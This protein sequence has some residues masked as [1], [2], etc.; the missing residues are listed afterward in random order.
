MSFAQRTLRPP[1]PWIALWVVSLLALAVGTSWALPPAPSR[2]PAAGPRLDRVRTD[3]DGALREFAE[4]DVAGD[5]FVPGRDAFEV[6]AWSR[7]GE[8]RVG[9]I[10][11]R[12][13]GHPVLGAQLRVVL[14]GEDRVRFVN[15]R[16]LWDL[17][18]PAQPSRTREQ[19]FAATR[20]TVRPR[21]ED[22]R[23][24]GSLAVSRLATGDHLVWVVDVLDGRG[25]ST[26]RVLVDAIDGRV[27]EVAEVACHA[28][29][30]VYPT[31][32]RAPL[33]ERAL[34]GW[35]G[36]S[37]TLVHS[38]YSVEARQW[39][40]LVVPDHDFRFPDG[41]PLAE[42]RREVNTYWHAQ[43]YLDDFLAPL[44]YAGPPEPFVLRV[45]E[46]LDPYIALTSGRFVFL[47]EAIAGLSRD[48]ALA[49]DIVAHELQH[50]V[51]YGFGV[52]ASGPR[53]EALALHEGVS[54]FMAACVTADPSIGEWAYVSF[55]G[56]VTRVDRPAST[57]KYS[58]YDRV[59]FGGVPTGSG[60]AN[61]M[62]LSG[63]LWDLRS[64][65]GP[66]TERL[67]LRA[68]A[69]LPDT[70]EWSHFVNAMAE[71]DLELTGGAHAA[72]L[73]QAFTA[74]E[75]RGSLSVSIGGPFAAK[76]GEA[77]TYQALVEG[78]TTQ[79][80]V[81]S[82]RRY[83]GNAP[84]GDWEVVGSGPSLM[85]SEVTDYELRASIVGLLG[86][87]EQVRFID[88]LSPGLALAGAPAVV[89]GE[90]QPYRADVTGVG[91]LGY[92]WWR[93]F[94]RPGAT[95]ERI[96]S[97]PT[98]N[99][100]ADAPYTLECRVTDALG[101]RVTRSVFVPFL[102]LSIEAPSRW[103]PGQA[104]RLLAVGNS[105]LDSLDLRW[106]VRPYCGSVPCEG[107]SESLGVGRQLDVAFNTDVLVELT[108][109]APWGSRLSAGTFL[110]V[111]WPRVGLLGPGVI[112]AR[113]AGLFV[114]D[115]NGLGPFAVQWWRRDPRSGVRTELGTGPS[116]ELRA[117]EPVD[118]VV[119][120]RDPLGREEETSR[121][122]DV[123]DV[124]G[125]GG[126][127]T[128][129]RF[130]LEVPGLANGR[131]PVRFQLAH[132]ARARV[133]VLDVTGRQV[134]RLWD[135]F[136]AAGAEELEWEPGGAGEGVYFVRLESGGRQLTRRIVL[137]P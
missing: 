119:Q 93:T 8:L 44:G 108:A 4:R 72:E 102:A 36:D 124:V 19:A 136:H 98:V 6:G 40:P 121:R 112:S 12:F 120:V 113:E 127:G 9:R 89:E 125:V 15:G 58:N 17:D 7:V 84:C 51:T 111:L 5:R 42:R 22:W 90:T 83:C 29:G 104:A 23:L 81:W 128:S 74:R 11:Q 39:P 21:G 32:P 65:I 76:P 38:Q 91:P 20:D 115:A 68:L 126:E 14:D 34:L 110:N 26:T 47:G 16:F 106:R 88:V 116:L 54:D 37:T 114:A 53:R 31:D 67:V 134:A 35:A 50:A 107:E 30:L 99:V 85:L 55:P 69:L 3:P 52:S 61:G 101:R 2:T 87:A 133:C 24:Q 82:V 18:A 71:A 48:A 92:E 75:I 73:T 97:G 57:F 130:A 86:S 122:I 79:P 129:L 94:A 45:G 103:T 46:P 109:T 25:A 96:G 49:D 64:M 135:G 62:I 27:L 95:R 43:R 137:L 56:G 123:L 118:L 59:A 80:L 70:P 77:V 13:H 105:W 33:E 60:W 63:A 10:S 41:H 132:S 1:I 78:V 100:R 131:V 28:P 117:T 66:I